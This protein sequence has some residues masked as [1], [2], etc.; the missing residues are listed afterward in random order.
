MDCPSLYYRQV[1][2]SIAPTPDRLGFAYA[3]RSKPKRS[4]LISLHTIPGSIRLR[5][6][7]ANERQYRSNRYWW[8]RAG[9]L[10]R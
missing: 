9:S 2:R 6:R 10:G 7:Y 1:A 8:G 4:T 3:T 5:L